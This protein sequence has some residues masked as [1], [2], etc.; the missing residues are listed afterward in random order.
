MAS[1]ISRADSCEVRALKIQ[2]LQPRPGGVPDVGLPGPERRRGAER[3]HQRLMPLVT[4]LRSET[5]HLGRTLGAR[6]DVAD[7]GA[8]D[9][10]EE[11]ISCRGR[12]RRAV[13]HQSHLQ[14]KR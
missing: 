14:S 8:K 7:V 9:A 6:R 4:E 10:I 5:F 3:D 13:Q 11:R 2:S 12:R 1:G